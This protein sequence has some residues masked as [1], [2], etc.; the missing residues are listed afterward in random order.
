MSEYQHILVATDLSNASF[1]PEKKARDLADKYGSKLSLVHTIEPIP[2]YG[3][4]GLVDL[5]SPFIDDAKNE[6]AKVGKKLNV[7]EDCQHVEFGAVKSQILKVAEE[8][9]VDLIIIGSHGR[10]GL[11]RLLG[12]GA[13]GIIHGAHCDVLVVR[14]SEE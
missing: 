12:S 9:N 13:S 14:Y 3:Y 4:P 6:M 5:E 8:L 7:P 10:H 1:V 2:A 11:N